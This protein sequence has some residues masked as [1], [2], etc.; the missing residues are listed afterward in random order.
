M[1]LG[2]NLIGTK[3]MGKGVKPHGVKIVQLGKVQC[4]FGIE[5]EVENQWG[6]IQ[7]P[8]QLLY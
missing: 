6:R 4:W 3:V 1:S 8:V 5:G 2:W 7:K